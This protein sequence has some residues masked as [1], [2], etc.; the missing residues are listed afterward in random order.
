MI[1]TLASECAAIW[2]ASGAGK[3]MASRS[4]DSSGIG[5]TAFCGNHRKLLTRPRCLSLS[6]L[7]LGRLEDDRHQEDRESREIGG[8]NRGIPDAEGEER[9]RSKHEPEKS[10]GEHE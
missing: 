6:E 3:A 4:L 7:E 5:A 9:N 1:E 2:R 8:E 10:E